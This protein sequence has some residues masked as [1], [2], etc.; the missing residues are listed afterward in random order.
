[1]DQGREVLVSCCPYCGSELNTV[2]KRL[3]AQFDIPRVPPKGAKDLKLT[4]AVRKIY[5]KKY[6]VCPKCEAKY[7]Y[8]DIP[9]YSYYKTVPHIPSDDIFL[10][11]FLIE[12]LPKY[13]PNVQY[14]ILNIKTVGP[15]KFILRRAPAPLVNPL[16]IVRFLNRIIGKSLLPLLAIAYPLLRKKGL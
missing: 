9:I 14:H 13:P 8:D 4:Y 12:E 11:D 6:A 10:R 7:Y 5:R 3:E 2:T 1:M 16:N 15:N